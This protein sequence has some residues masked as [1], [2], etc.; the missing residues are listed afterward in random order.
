[1]AGGIDSGV[2]VITNLRNG[3]RYVGS[4]VK[5][6]YRLRKHRAML[7]AG[8]HHSSILQ[9]AWNKH[10][11]EAFSFAQVLA[12]ARDNL[13]MYEQRLIDGYRPEYN[14]LP[15]AGSALGRVVSDEHKRKIGDANRGKV[16]VISAEHRAAISAA[17]KGRA[18]PTRSEAHRAALSIGRKGKGL[19]P[20]SI[21]TREAI[22]IALVGRKLSE[23]HRLN[24]SNA[25]RGRKQNAEHVARAAAARLGK[26][27]G[28][29]KSRKVA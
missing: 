2:Y 14:V 7:V 17:C 8:N 21:E 4:S 15:N 25:L 20:K 22:S 24:L 6:R 10:G 13:I 18:K 23:E 5:V 26:K 28:P 27:R 1:M 11:C 3:K 9:S 19:G 16:M 12:C 29:Y